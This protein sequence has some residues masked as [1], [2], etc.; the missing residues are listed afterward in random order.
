MEND[1]DLSRDAVLL[2]KLIDA[3]KSNLD[4]EQFGVAELSEAVAISRFQLH[5]KL[6][7]LKGK[8]VSQFIREVRLEEARKMLLADVGTAAEISY[9]VGF[10]NPTYFNKCFRDLY[11]YSPGE[12]RRKHAAEVSALPSEIPPSPVTVEDRGL[13]RP[14]HAS[15]VS[16][17]QN[18][19]RKIWL[20]AIPVVIVVI[21]ASIYFLLPQKSNQVAIAILPLDDL[22]GQ[23]EEA[24]FVSGMH[25]ALIGQ[26]G[27]VS[28]LRVISRTST[29]RYPNREMLLKDIARELGVDAIVEG[30]VYG[31]GDSVR[32]Q[33]QLIEVFPRE[34]HVWAKEYHE[35]IRNALTMHSTVVQDIAREIQVSLTAEEESKLKNVREVNSETY[36]NYLRAMF[37]INQFN[38]KE[39]EKG[40]SI[41]QES[42]KTDPGDP[43]PWAGLAVGYSTIGHSPSAF[44][45][46]YT[47]AK[48]AANKAISLDD[49]LAEAHLALAL[50][51]LYDEWD[52]AVAEREFRKAIAINPNL[53]SAHTHYAW[54]LMLK[55]RIDEMWRHSKLAVELD[56]FLSLYSGYLAS[57]Y[58]YTGQK[59]RAL[60]EVTRVLEFD[61]NSDFALFVQGAVYSSTDMHDKAVEIHEKAAEL[62]KQWKWPLATTYA[63]AGRKDDALAMT[64]E[65][66]IDPRPVEAWGLA[67]AYAAM[68]ETDEAFRWLE[69]AYSDRFSW[70]PWIDW[71]PNFQPLRHD[72]RFDQMLNL[73]KLPPSIMRESPSVPDTGS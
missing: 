49:N 55:N 66:R 6:K 34:R 42:I 18:T 44:G 12:T 17:R 39:V 2:R 5:R 14:S 48:A 40:I 28:G 4:N 20:F 13:N 37:H 23:P 45:H 64:A 29:L 15:L 65:L 52:W 25:D 35:D 71:N 41:L 8:S 67:E 61:P 54:L 57:Q 62:N 63:Y 7:S 73:L 22:T 36:R 53:A 43:L 9:R 19:L 31:V 59:E 70:M 30:S 51:A 16:S 3:V 50:V 27:Q 56:P 58:W 47:H 68:G 1:R 11:G 33:L 69:R 10:N 26:L 32:I 38:L 24:F 21:L 72:P 60:E 46:A